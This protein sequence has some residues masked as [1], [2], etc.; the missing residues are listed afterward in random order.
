[1]HRNIDQIDCLKNNSAPTPRIIILKEAAD[2]NNDWTPYAS[3]PIS[4]LSS[5]IVYKYL[6]TYV[7][8][9]PTDQ[10]TKLAQNKQPTPLQNAPNK[11]STNQIYS[12]FFSKYKI[13]CALICGSIFLYILYA[14][15]NKYI[16]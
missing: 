2:E 8:N 5:F 6:T 4:L 10:R 3:L 1:M 11:N 15:S 14:Y 7:K 9:N 12:Y 13:K 16:R